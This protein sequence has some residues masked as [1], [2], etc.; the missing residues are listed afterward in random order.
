MTKTAETIATTIAAINTRALCNRRIEQA[1]ARLANAEEAIHFEREL[2]AA[3]EAHIH[4]LPEE[5]ASV[6]ANVGDTVVFKLGHGDNTR[7]VEG[8][9]RAVDGAKYRVLI[10]EGFNQE[11]KTVFAGSVIEVRQADELGLE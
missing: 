7:Q 4:T 1:K 11:F 5:A 6:R 2:I 9:V 10:G 3:L 8:V